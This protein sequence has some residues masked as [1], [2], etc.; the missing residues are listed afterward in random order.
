[1]WV[2]VSVSFNVF[3]R[4]NQCK[5]KT[6]FCCYGVELLHYKLKVYFNDSLCVKGFEA[7]YITCKVYLNYFGVM[8]SWKHF[9]SKLTDSKKI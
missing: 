6:T 5:D 3:C 7:I 8:Y 9:F 1:M 2:T 4:E